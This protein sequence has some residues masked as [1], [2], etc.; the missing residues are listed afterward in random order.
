MLKVLMI[1]LPRDTASG[2]E[3]A[4]LPTLAAEDGKHNA[5]RQIMAITVDATGNLTIHTYHFKS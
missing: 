3:V 5:R 2:L 1:G 4:H